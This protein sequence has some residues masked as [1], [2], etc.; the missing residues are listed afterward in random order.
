MNGVIQQSDGPAEDAAE[1]FG[2]DQAKRGGHGPAE[3]RRA[4]RRVLVTRV[5]VRMGVVHMT[6]VMTMFGIMD[7]ITSLIVTVLRVLNLRM[8]VHPFHF[9]HL[10]DAVQPLLP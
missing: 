8:L 4:Q 6:V 7:L 5:M 1:N 10:R 2:N 9:T 3:D